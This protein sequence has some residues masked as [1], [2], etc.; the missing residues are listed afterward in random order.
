MSSGK[1]R[2]VKGVNESNTALAKVNG[3]ISGLQQA[4]FIA[5]IVGV[6]VLILSFF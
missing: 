6:I 5:A 3:L 4:F 1:E 2:Y